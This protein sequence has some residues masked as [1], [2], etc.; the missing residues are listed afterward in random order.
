MVLFSTCALTQVTF[1][2]VPLP[3]NKDMG[4][5]FY[6]KVSKSQKIKHYIKF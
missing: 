6:G 5:I 1:H 4:N 3:E 2:F